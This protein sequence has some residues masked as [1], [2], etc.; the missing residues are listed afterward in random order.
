MQNERIPLIIPSYEPDDR[1]ITLLQ[2]L[3]SAGFTNI[4]VLDDG[5]GDAYQELFARVE[6]EYG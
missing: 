6:N 1:L 5:S 3:K 2:N 4:V